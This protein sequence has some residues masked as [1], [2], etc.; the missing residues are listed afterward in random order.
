MPIG[1][2]KILIFIIILTVIYLSLLPYS[3][4]YAQATALPD[5]NQVTQIQQNIQK[6]SAK[7]DILRTE[8]KAWQYPMTCIQ[9]AEALLELA[10]IRSAANTY[11]GAQRA[12][13]CAQ[14]T[15]ENVSSHISEEMLNPYYL[16]DFRL[17]KITS[18]SFITGQSYDFIINWKCINKLEKKTVS[19][20]YVILDEHG[21]I[22]FETIHS[23]KKPL[24][25]K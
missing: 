3:S 16:L 5:T 20:Q 19:L 2:K 4:E 25:Q 13:N 1:L 12:L 10:N 18:E 9:I 17:F 8:A 15:L 23:P 14:N 11:K 22:I 7:I 21:Q 24:F 6:L